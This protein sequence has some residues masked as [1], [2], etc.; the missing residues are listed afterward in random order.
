MLRLVILGLIFISNNIFAADE[1]D[2]A[3]WRQ[4]FYE[5]Q[6]QQ[7]EQKKQKNEREQAILDAQ[8]IVEQ[9]RMAAIKAQQRKTA[10]E[11]AK[12]DCTGKN[13]NQA[14]FEER[15]ICQA[16]EAYYRY[17]LPVPQDIIR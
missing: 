17:G 5:I 2:D 7:L 8:K 1:C 15:K 3:C 11:A 6:R 9:E 16:V 4:R 10:I 12:K 13:L 14:T